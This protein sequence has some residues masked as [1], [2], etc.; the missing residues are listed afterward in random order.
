V[1]RAEGWTGSI[2]GMQRRT[3]GGE[4]LR[5]DA[6]VVDDPQDDEMAKSPERVQKFLDVLVKVI[7]GLGGHDRKIS[8]MVQ[9]TMIAKGDAVDRLLDRT[10]Y[11]A[12][13]ANNTPMLRALPATQALW[14]E[15][16]AK[17]RNDFRRDAPGDQA[18]ARA[19]STAFY[20]SN[21]EAMDA[22]AEV[23][24]DGLR[25][26]DEVSGLQHAMDLW[27][28]KGE[29]YFRAECQGSPIDRR[30]TG[31]SDLDRD[32]V[33]RRV[34][35]LGRRVLPAPAG[36]ITAFVDMGRAEL[37]WL[38]VAW[39]S[40]A[41]GTI[42]DYGTWP[43]QRGASLLDQYA[44]QTEAAAGGLASCLHRVF[45]AQYTREDG[46]ALNVDLAMVD[47]GDPATR[48]AVFGVC[49]GA[50]FGSPVIASRGRAHH[51]FRRPKDRRV[52]LYQD[53][54]L[55]LW[56]KLG[57]VVIHDACAWRERVQS[58]LS[59]AEGAP[60]EIRLY[61]PAGTQHRELAEHLT[62]EIL[63]EKMVGDTGEYYKWQQ[64]GPN[65]W[66]DCL[67]GCAVGASTLGIAKRA[68][69]VPGSMGSA[70]TGREPKRRRG[71]FRAVEG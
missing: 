39:D 9:A 17:I 45:G 47:C 12:W 42:V 69:V 3:S 30:P 50:R 4:V 28:D 22:G 61:G 13:Q 63:L 24:D 8:C 20:Q 23:T 58:S 60:G 29:D 31:L 51:K 2:R 70:G 55:D 57:R 10:Q 36:T 32:V 33:S 1:I 18:R 65:H 5:P 14:L 67:V 59:C 68:T 25:E 34:S 49:R 46:A 27:I 19:A 16:Y 66:L 48:D 40:V 11:P 54:Y 26:G 71:G 15:D 41:S 21:R 37:W 52:R 44:S 35:G 6:V 7:L 38:V 56:R 64:Q 53:A 43:E 62:A